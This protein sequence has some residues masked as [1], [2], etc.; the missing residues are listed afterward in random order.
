[1]SNVNGFIINNGVLESY[2]GNESYLVIPEGVTCLGS[3][4]WGGRLFGSNDSAIQ[5][6]IIPNTV[7]CI[8]HKAF[9]GCFNLSEVTIPES[10]QSIGQLAFAYCSSLKAISI[11]K[12]V[13]GIN[14]NAFNSC[15]SLTEAVIHGDISDIAKYAFQG[16]TSL[17]KIV[18]HGVVTNIDKQAFE[19]IPADAIITAPQTPLDVFS[20]RDTKHAAVVG[21]LCA[22]DLYTDPAVA[23]GYRMYAISHK[24]EFLPIVISLDL[25][26]SIALFV[27]SKKLTVAAFRSE[28]LETA[29]KA[30]AAG[31]IAYLLNWQNQNFSAESLDADKQK[32]QTKD[33]YNAA[34]MKKIWSTQ[35]LPDGSLAITSYKGMDIHV[36]IPERIGKKAVTVIGENA[37]NAIN[38]QRASRE[39]MEKIES[40]V[41][42]TSVTTIEKN[43]FAYCHALKEIVIPD[44]ITTIAFYGIRDCKSL[45]H[46][47]IPASVE[48]IGGWNFFSTGFV[49]SK[50]VITQKTTIHTPAGSRAEFYAK[51]AD[52]PL[53]IE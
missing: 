3:M 41:I 25:A 27:E 26:K 11:P 50:N 5:S 20:T 29:E 48:K 17:R 44:S 43:A 46:I 49:G 38:K 45:E 37:F 47:H 28:Y 39:L 8:S 40:V 24:K 21:F 13:K 35:S 31:C 1:M 15:T 30:N 12:G 9:S 53:V 19:G 36:V 42:P 16:C 51:E 6:V 7:T 18:F 22:P 23:T 52:L 33:P 14:Y 34:D 32:Q 10:V 2:K 4:P